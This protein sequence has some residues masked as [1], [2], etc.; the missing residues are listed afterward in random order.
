[1]KNRAAKVGIDDHLLIDGTLKSNDSRQNTLSEFSRK[2]RLK[3]RRDISVLYAFDLEKNG[4]HLFAV[5]SR[6]YARS[7]IL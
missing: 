4:A 5:L 6:Q 3:G 1:M 2:A 7:D